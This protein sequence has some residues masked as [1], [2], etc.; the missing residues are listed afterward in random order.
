[1]QKNVGKVLELYLSTNQTPSRVAQNK[2]ALNEGGIIGDKFHSKNILR[3]VL[4]SSTNSYQIAKDNEISIDSGALG[5]NI[6]LDCDLSHLQAGEKIQI[7][8]VVLE[9]TQECTVCKG[10]TQIHNKLPKLLK[11]D[12]GIFSKVVKDGNIKIS[13][14]VNI[15]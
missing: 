14:I 1:M 5:E 6:L 13:D 9:I 10:L 4:L 3:S 15:L 8:E 12:R 11:K 2:L 7:G